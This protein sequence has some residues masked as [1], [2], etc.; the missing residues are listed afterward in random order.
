MTD[1][2]GYGDDQDEAPPSEDDPG[3]RSLSDAETASWLDEPSEEQEDVSVI[4][5]DIVSAP[6]DW[7][8]ATL[9]NFMESGA[10]KIP[11]FQRNLCGTKS[12]HRN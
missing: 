11:A 9:V 6:N 8:F 2:Y 4:E 1:E 5:Y 3:V 12:E 10:L 7:N